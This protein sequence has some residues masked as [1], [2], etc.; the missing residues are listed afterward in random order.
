M[1]LTSLYSHHMGVY[2][3]GS[4]LDPCLTKKLISLKKKVEK[5]VHYIVNGCC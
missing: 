2:E 1:M 5:E 4:R 3:Q